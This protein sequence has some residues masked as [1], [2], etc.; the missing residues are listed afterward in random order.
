MYC[1]FFFFFFPFSIHGLYI[2]RISLWESLKS[3]LVLRTSLHLTNV[4]PD[5]VTLWRFSPVIE[6]N[7]ESLKFNSQFESGNLRKAVQVRK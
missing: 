5:S 4:L 7:G 2:K 3:L 1:P 6:D